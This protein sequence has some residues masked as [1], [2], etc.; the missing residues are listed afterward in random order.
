MLEE[1]EIEVI[2]VEE[3]DVDIIKDG[4]VSSVLEAY[5]LPVQS[6][7]MLLVLLYGMFRFFKIN[8]NLVAAS[9]SENDLMER[10]ND[11][12]HNEIPPAIS[13]MQDKWSYQKDPS[14]ADKKRDSKVGLSYLNFLKNCHSLNMLGNPIC[15][16]ICTSY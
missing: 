6:G 16:S 13:L 12:Y 1:N 2:A 8:Y 3:S 7:I 14:R 15:G 4:R 11:F 9:P 5:V 10:R